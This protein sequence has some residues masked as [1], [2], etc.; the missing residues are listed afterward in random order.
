MVK[1]GV[2]GAVA[3]HSSELNAADTAMCKSE[4]PVAAP[5]AAQESVSAAA[6]PI[7][8]RARVA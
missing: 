7:S 5:V 1:A 2:L 4:E 3:A 8:T 6:L